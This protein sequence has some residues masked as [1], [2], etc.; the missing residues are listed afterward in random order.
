[1]VLEDLAACCFHILLMMEI[2]YIAC[3]NA[4]CKIVGLGLDFE[5]SMYLECRFLIRLY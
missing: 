3:S 1:M 2:T 4:E 5:A